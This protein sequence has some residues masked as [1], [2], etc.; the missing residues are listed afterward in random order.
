MHVAIIGTYPPT[1]CGIATFTADVEQALTDVGLDVDVVVVDPDPA[2]VGR[3]APTIRSDDA[4]SYKAAAEWLNQSGVDMVLIEH[5]FGIHGGLDG[6]HL[7]HLTESLRV[8]YVLTLHTVLDHFTAS[9][10]VTLEA[11]CSRAAAVTVFTPAARRMILEQE[12][13]LAPAVTIVPHGAPIELYQPSG[14]SLQFELGLAEDEQVVSTFGLLS[15]GKGIEVAIRAMRAVVDEVPGARYVVA[16][17]THPGVQRNAGE[18]YRSELQ[19]LVEDLGLEERV[20]FVDRFLT[21]DEIAELLAMTRVFLTPYRNPDQIVSGALTFAVAAGCPV[22]STPYRYGRDLV[23]SGAG[24]LV[25]F[26]DPAAFSEAVLRLLPD[27]P[28]RSRALSEVGTLSAKLSWPAVGRT[29]QQTLSAALD[30]VAG[31]R[32]VPVGHRVAPSP[33]VNHLLVL[34]DDTSVL[35]HA[36]LR[37]PRLEEGYCVDDAAR[38]LPVA[39]RIAGEVGKDARFEVAVPR[40]LAF[41]RAAARDGDGLMRN[42]M[43]WS[44]SWLDDPHDGDHVGRA[45]WGLGELVASGHYLD[46]ANALLQDLIRRPVAF[47]WPRLVAYR[48]LGLLAAADHVDVEGEL[49]AT[50]K[51]V[52]AWRSTRSTGNWN[53][54]EPRMVYDAART[55]E[56][57]MRLG[58]QLNDSAMVDRG[59]EVFGWLEQIC[60][61]GDYYR[62]P[63]HLGME[64]GSRLS[65]SGDEQPLEASAMID[66]AAACFEIT[67]DAWADGVAE[68]AWSWFLGNN[69]VG[70]PLG[71]LHHGACRDAIT[72]CGLNENC[73]AESTI[74]FHRSAHTIAQVRSHQ[75]DSSPTSSDGLRAPTGTP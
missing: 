27:G 7:L 66:A 8:P 30:R 17:R 39:A 19:L 49:A 29:L 36:R 15:P 59:V 34:V 74:A 9:Q 3:S 71:S 10:S 46:E 75:R 20:T 41:L 60:R 73:G 26:D 44:R 11:L 37:L 70:K 21:V 50:Y 33:P 12:L 1:R 51:H 52:N 24:L 55:P 67:G 4:L 31:G 63:G 13:A 38:L 58:H 64:P 22:V 2:H 61:E 43:T 54:P 47:P 57:L 69:R 68:R 14:R 72:A 25:P 62:F 56:V 28:H 18:E 6:A 32:F 35:Q 40:M 45:I 53:W 16:G 65:L 5:E 23:G 48:A 42:F